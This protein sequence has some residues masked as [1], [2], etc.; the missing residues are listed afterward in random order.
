MTQHDASLA[1]S[2]FAPNPDFAQSASGVSKGS[3]G[4]TGLGKAAAASLLKGR[5]ETMHTEHEHSSISSEFRPFAA[6]RRDH[7]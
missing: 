2:L 3:R 4:A 7:D 5:S 6:A 1:Y